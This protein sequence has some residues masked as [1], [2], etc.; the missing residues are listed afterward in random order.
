MQT[1]LGRR[2]YWGTLGGLSLALLVVHLLIL[3]IIVAATTALAFRLR[4]AGR[5]A[6]LALIPVI[7]FV[8]S[9][10]IGILGGLY[11]NRSVSGN[12]GLSLIGMAIG[13]IVGMVQY[14]GFLIWAGTLTTRTDQGEQEIG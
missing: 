5:S 13:V 9:S 1:K 7:I 4:D 2:P 3:P 10:S 14:C 11:L 12:D 8:L 6:W